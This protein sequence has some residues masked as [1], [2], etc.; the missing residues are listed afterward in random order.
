MRSAAISP[1]NLTEVWLD[2]ESTMRGAAR[3]AQRS[4]LQRASASTSAV[5]SLISQ[6][7][8]VVL[9]RCGLSQIAERP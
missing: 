6:L 5:A 4:A 1:V 8:G 2:S 3:G 7:E 9:A